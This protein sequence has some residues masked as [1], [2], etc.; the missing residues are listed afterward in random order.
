[1]KSTIVEVDFVTYN[2]SVPKANNWKMECLLCNPLGREM[3][4]NFLT[5]SCFKTCF[6]KISICLQNHS[7]IVLDSSEVSTENGKTSR[8][9]KPEMEIQFTPLEP[10]KMEVKHQG[11][12]L[13]VRVKMPK[14]RKKRKSEEVVQV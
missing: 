2:R 4:Y 8:F 13:P 7:G 5:H 11:S 10:N 1:L 3:C 14:S 9:P 6:L 12:A